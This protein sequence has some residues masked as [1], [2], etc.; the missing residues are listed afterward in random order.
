MA[1]LRKLALREGFSSLAFLT[2]ALLSVAWSVEAANW[3][4]GLS[5]MPTITVCAIALGVLLAKA[6]PVPR[7]F[8]HF[9]AVLV[10]IWL[11]LTQMGTL[12]PADAGGWQERTAVVLHHL[13]SW[14]QIV[15]AGRSSNDPLMFAGAL[16][17]IFWGAG[18]AAAWSVFRSHKLWWALLPPGLIFVI[19]ASYGRGALQWHFVAFTL[20]SLL[21]VVRMNMFRNQE[22]WETLNI[23]Y[24]GMIVWR[25][26][27][28]GL[29]ICCA[30][31]FVAGFLPIREASAGP[32]AAVWDQ[33]GRPLEAVQQEW[34][35]AFWSLGSGRA[36]AT[37]SSF[38]S[39]F[40]LGSGVRLGDGPVL[41][42]KS[43]SPSYMQG[44]TYDTYTGRGWSNTAKDT[45]NPP[46][47]NKDLAP[48][49]LQ[50]AG[51]PIQGTEYQMRKALTQT[52]TILGDGI[53]VVLGAPQ[54]SSVD[55][56]MLLLPSWR[57]LNMD[58]RTNVTSPNSY[59]LELRSLLTQLQNASNPG[60]HYDRQAVR[61]E[62]DALA[63]KGIT[64]SGDFRGFVH[65]DYQIT[66]SGLFATY[67]DITGLR[68]RDQQPSGAQYT[69]TSLVS[70]ADKASLRLASNV[71]P[72]WVTDRY[73]QVPATLP[74][75]V[76]DLALQLTAGK[77]NVYDKAEAIEAYLRTYKYSTSITP[78]PQGRDVVDY[79]LF[80]EKAG[81][82]EYFSTAMVVMLRSIGIPAREVTGYT[83]GT[84]DEAS[85]SYIVKESN[86]HAWPQV[87]FPSYGWVNFEPTPSQPPV[88]RSAGAGAE[89]PSQAAGNS[90]N[91]MN[92]P[93]R[94]NNRPFDPGSQLSGNF[95]IDAI[96]TAAGSG[97]AKISA[98]FF[99]AVVLFL[100]V[101]L[102]L[103]RMG[104]DHLRS[105]SLAYAKLC[106]AG[107]WLGVN[108]RTSQT[109]FEFGR[110]LGDALPGAQRP[111]SR[112]VSRYVEESYSDR[113][114]DSPAGDPQSYWLQ[115]RRLFLRAFLLRP[116]RWLR[117]GR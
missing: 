16:A 27:W 89:T 96:G 43:D 3:V 2:V 41:S 84:F 34:N 94:F 35:R 61:A 114:A 10:G 13:A 80:D 32:F 116:F 104:L 45:F 30:V 15:H 76:R 14:L 66:V 106:K 11:I 88:Y 20:A 83:S 63:K 39:A 75:R 105:T 62:I 110:T 56:P 112:I 22:R 47:A 48:T 115:V 28:S 40:N 107:A 37:Y 68:F 59:P 85:Q 82:C 8:S 4:P 18:Y 49:L 92:D 50:P 55:K 72:G 46:E 6:T 29:L 24:P 100:M 77:S 64:V 79:F 71:Y 97:A 109:P 52:V 65:G 86:A 58:I 54:V 81:Y 60:G 117:R 26:V 23:R 95:A 17:V 25:S 7:F 90:A 9:L 113:K 101:L 36:V 38:S 93:S 12:L 33:V 99:G 111:V 103:W 69:V 67:D 57:S 19:N 5:I 78:V 98:V 21:L 1:I 53:D 87:F 102:L 31:L 44:M 51:S 74:A 42:V 91:P 108:I 73:L 70:E